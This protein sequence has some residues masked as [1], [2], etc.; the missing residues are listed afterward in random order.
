MAAVEAG[1]PIVRRQVAPPAG[2]VQPLPLIAGTEPFAAEWLAKWH[3]MPH[4][5]PERDIA[6]YSAM[7]G[8]VSGNGQVWLSGRLVTS[9]E[10][11]PAYVAHGLDVA[12]GGNDRL[13]SAAA[14][15]VRTI[16]APCLVS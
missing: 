3:S 13:H 16:D 11:M 4:R 8:I 10:I 7:D 9:P 12:N 2:G 1:L 14:L 15:P 5:W 6:C